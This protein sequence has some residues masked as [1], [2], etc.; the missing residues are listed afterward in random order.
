MGSG[1]DLGG[2][3]KVLSEVLETLV[4]EGVE[5]PLPAELGVDETLGG[6]A[7]DCDEEF[8]VRSLL[9]GD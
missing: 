2:E 5:V 4:S 3:V 6:Q 8:E 1:D 9:S 7:V